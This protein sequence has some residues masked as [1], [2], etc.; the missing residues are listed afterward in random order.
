M[1]A[2]TSGN[3][4]ESLRL[5]A[6][7][8]ELNLKKELQKY[9]ESSDPEGVLRDTARAKAAEDRLRIQ[10]QISRLEKETWAEN[11]AAAN[12]LKSIQE[13]IA[14]EQQRPGLT[15]TGTGALQAIKAIEDARRAQRNAEAALRADPQNN[16]LLN[17]SQI[18]AKQVRLAAAK[19]RADLLE[20]Y[21]SAKEAVRSIS[22]SIE[23]AVTA[24]Q[25]LQNTSGSGLNEFRSPQQVVDNQAAVF[26][27][28]NA[29][30]NEIAR[31]RGLNFTLSGSLEQRNA[32]LLRLVRG[33]RQETRLA[34]DIFQGRADLNVAQND[35]STVTQSLVNVNG[36][37]A[38]AT[39]EL[40]QKNWT[41]NVAVDA[42]SGKY[43]INLG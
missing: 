28:L 26:Q 14:I 15:S 33:D 25:E 31:R 9:N 2:D 11:I 4:Q 38:T 21:D 30:A 22:R 8:V 40:A 39:A 12:Q 20:A 19:T 16:N 24:L 37:L 3:K 27:Q 32:A 23:D 1:I 29:Q 5:Q 34:Q 17:A 18:A 7:Q 6:L 10:Q 13:E 36:Q 41:V 35:L 43:A 42:N